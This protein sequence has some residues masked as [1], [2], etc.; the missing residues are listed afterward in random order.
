[1][2]ILKL[3]MLSMAMMS[4]C[5]CQEPQLLSDPFLQLPSKNGIWVVWFTSF[6]GISHQVE[7]GEAKESRA[8]AHSKRM[9]HLYEDI[10]RDGISIGS[11]QV[12]IW[13]H[14]AFVKG[15]PEGVRTPY[16]VVSETEDHTLIYSKIFSLSPAPPPGQPLKILFTSDHQKKPM[17]A[18]NLQK[19]AEK[20]GYFDAVFFAGDLI[21]YPNN[22]HDWFTDPRGFF[23][24]LQGHAEGTLEGK[25]YSGGAII[26]HAPVFPAIGN[27]DVTG[28]YSPTAS[29][30]HQ[31][32]N[33]YP[34]DKAALLFPNASEKELKKQSF[35]TD[36]YEEIF[37]LPGQDANDGRATY[38]A[39]TIGEIRLIVLYA[40]RIWRSPQPD[41]CKGRYQE[42][43][44][45]FS[46][47]EQWGYGDF[48]FESLSKGSKQYNWLHDELQSQAFQEA[49]LHIVMLHHPFH[50]LGV[51]AIPPFTDPE[52][53]IQRD[54][55]GEISAIHYHYPLEKDILI[56]EIEPLLEKYGVDLVLYGHSHL[57]NRFQSA[58]GMHFLETSNVGNSHGAYTR[59]SRIDRGSHW[60]V[61]MANESA[62]EDPNGLTAIVP[63]LAPLKNQE[64]DSLP[65][66]AS[67]ELT[68]F[69]V[70]DTE[71]K[72]IDSYYFNCRHPDQGIV[73]FDSFSPYRASV[74]KMQ[75][76][77]QTET[78]ISVEKE[79]FQTISH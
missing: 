18:A 75:E 29:L 63:T 5:L 56:Q 39:V 10:K 17:V 46:H 13:R 51:N 73:K 6:Q 22:Y 23:P 66:I 2:T 32:Q 59:D 55:K 16:R 9:S 26:Q 72:V 27:H 58:K 69:S 74:S 53:I 45:S 33:A 36:A 50:S 24:C 77:L 71:R 43:A 21:E 49:K 70:L 67:N 65:Y 1:M 79:A 54:E 31:I 37:T 44:N 20:I 60:N 4:S 14:E 11:Q 57:W 40:T 12:S 38:Y 35:N 48:I 76:S 41:C 8:A 19:A 52:Q 47:P 34:R 64:G 62:W 25:F 78:A 3:W 28:R 61:K 15:I 30:H 42:S 68:V 7:W